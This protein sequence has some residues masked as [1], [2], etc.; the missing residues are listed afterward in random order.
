MR[1]KGLLSGSP[2][3][4]PELASKKGAALPFLWY[5]FSFCFSEHPKDVREGIFVLAGKA[6]MR[7]KLFAR[8]YPSRCDS[9]SRRF[10]AEI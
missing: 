10:L 7:L 9:H 4:T 5:G 3:R 6:Q 1:L 2:L 8:P